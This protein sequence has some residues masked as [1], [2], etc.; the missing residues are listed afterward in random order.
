MNKRTIHD[1]EEAV[2]KLNENVRNAVEFLGSRRDI[3]DVKKLPL[4]THDL[5]EAIQGLNKLIR[6]NPDDPTHYINRGNAYFYIRNYER[7]ISDYSKFIQIY[8]DNAKAYLNCGDAHFCKGEYDKAI[9][10]YSKAIKLDPEYAEAYYARS[11][12][13]RHIGESNQAR[14]DEDK[15]LGLGFD[16]TIYVEDSCLE[17]IEELVQ[18][19][20]KNAKVYYYRGLVRDCSGDYNL[21][22]EDYN[23]VL[24]LNPQFAPA[25]HKRAEIYTYSVIDRDPRCYNHDKVISNY[26]KAISDYDK[27]QQLGYD[28]LESDPTIELF[29]Q[30]G[31][32]Y[33]KKENY[34]RAIADMS[35]VI[36]RDESFNTDYDEFVLRR[37]EDIYLGVNFR[38]G[39]EFWSSDYTSSHFGSDPSA[40]AYNNRGFYYYKKGEEDLAITDFKEALRLYNEQVELDPHSNPDFAMI[41]LNLGSVYQAKRDYDIAIENYDNVVRICPNY[42]EDFVNSKFANGGQE[43]VEKAIELLDSIY[44]SPPQSKDD[45]YYTGVR[46]L[47][48]ND[49]LSAERWFQIALKLGYGDCDKINQHLENLKM[50]E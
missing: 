13:Y 47:F 33:A 45:F 19:C 48:R 44:F 40:R 20:P 46:A 16:E 21:A 6:E 30:R 28:Y 25:Y 41:Y 42:V 14:A 35:E 39:E 49:R 23:K 15:A 31:E 17:L 24:Q 38:S 34:D 7:A 1:L 4:T 36:R 8:P 27:A 5:E 43:E 2:R 26:D 50:Y 11:N 37:D 22:I 3:Y 29:F 10:D 18:S 9:S 32:I 12:V